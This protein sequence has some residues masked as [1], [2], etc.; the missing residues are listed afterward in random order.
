METPALPSAAGQGESTDSPFT[1]SPPF[2][3]CDPGG[4]RGPKK[5]QISV[6]PKKKAEFGRVQNPG[7]GGGG[8]LPHR[9]AG[10]RSDPPKGGGH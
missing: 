7:P 1:D 8:G 2:S 4:G 3:P 10:V 9:G 5:H 6:Q